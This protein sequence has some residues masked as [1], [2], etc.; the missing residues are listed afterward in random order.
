MFFHF[1]TTLLFD[2]SFPSVIESVCHSVHGSPS[3][4]WTRSRPSATA[5]NVFLSQQK[6]GSLASTIK[7]LN[8]QVR[9]HVVNTR[10]QVQ[11]LEEPGLFDFGTLDHQGLHRVNLE[12][13]WSLSPQVYSTVN[14]W[15]K[16][17]VTNVW[18]GYIFFFFYIRP[19]SC[20]LPI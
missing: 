12:A 4:R 18:L 6:G 1:H 11:A 7:G 19:I 15:K 17:W 5:Q 10:V 20:K 14:V 16:K 8:G 9:V 2:C 13:V 3:L